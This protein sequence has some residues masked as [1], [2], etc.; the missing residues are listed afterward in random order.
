MSVDED[1]K[2]LVQLTERLRRRR[3]ELGVSA[4]RLAERAG[5]HKNTL[6]R[7]EAGERRPTPETLRLLAAELELDEVELFALAGHPLPD[8]LP[9][10]LPAFPL[11]LRTKYRMPKEAADQ[12][13]DYFA[14]LS[15]KYDITADDD[16]ASSSS[17]G[18]SPSNTKG[19]HAK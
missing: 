6:S 7:I 16:V 14:Y 19:G 18:D 17:S 11:Y 4:R 15:Q 1:K 2:D 9:E 8:R 10:R 5:L 13:K 3:E 12:L